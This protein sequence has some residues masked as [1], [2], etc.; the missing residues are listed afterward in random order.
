MLPSLR[1]NK[2]YLYTAEVLLSSWG[3]FGEIGTSVSVYTEAIRYVLDNAC[4]C[5]RTDNTEN[6]DLLYY[7]LPLITLILNKFLTTERILKEFNFGHIHPIKNEVN[8]I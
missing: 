1:N 2:W 8:Q 4:C 3:F 6:T 7:L 5:L